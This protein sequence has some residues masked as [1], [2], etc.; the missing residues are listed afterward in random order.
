MKQSALLVSSFLSCCFSVSVAAKPLKIGYSDWPGW[1][2]WDIAIEK[3]WF[4]E[5]NVEVEF[6]WMDYV[7]SMD[8]YVAGELDAV[9]MTNGDALVTGATGKPSTCILLNDFSYGND[10]VVAAPGIK[11]FADLSG[12]S[13]GLEEGF[14]GHLLFLTGMQEEGLDPDSIKIVNTNTGKIADVL[15]TGVVQ[16]VAGWQPNSG[17]ALKAV[18]GSTEIFSSADVPGIIFD[19][20]FVDRQNLQQNRREWQKVAK[21]WYRIV[22]FM[23]DETKQEEVL[24]ILSK[25]VG[26]SP[27]E[28]SELLEGTYI[29]SFEQAQRCWTKRSSIS[30]IYGSSKFVDDF[31]VKFKVYEDKQNIDAYFDPS[32]TQALAPQLEAK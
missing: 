15:R 3:G 8:A 11:S 20:L 32:L 9:C 7:D 19:G 13:V 29:L 31:N 26:L 25:R 22:D 21:V 24:A 6:Q 16:A 4:A 5:E 30:S 28:Y 1:V 12:Q 18:E 17:A 14:V 10:K 23:K 27:S 2:A